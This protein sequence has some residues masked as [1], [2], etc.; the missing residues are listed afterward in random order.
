MHDLF[1]RTIHEDHINIDVATIPR[2]ALH[3][4]ANTMHTFIK[5]YILSKP[6]LGIEVIS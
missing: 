1:C 4:Q 6:P 2:L 5:L 3:I